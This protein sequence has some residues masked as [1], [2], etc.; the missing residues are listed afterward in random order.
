VAA[1][2]CAEAKNGQILVTQRVAAAVESTAELQPLGDLALKGLSRPVTVMN[3]SAIAADEAA[4]K[5]RA[6]RW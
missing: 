3:V 2:L 4:V 6:I 1:R 5:A